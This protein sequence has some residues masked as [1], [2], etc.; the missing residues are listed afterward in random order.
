MKRFLLF[1]ALLLA[2]P[3]FAADMIYREGANSVR[4]KTSACSQKV[5]LDM[6]APPVQAQWFDAEATVNGKNFI[7]CWRP[8]GDAVIHLLYEDGDQGLIPRSN[9]RP[10]KSV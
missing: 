9:F 8:M 10:A 7:A 3:A 6:L 5:V 1:V 2:L 4:L